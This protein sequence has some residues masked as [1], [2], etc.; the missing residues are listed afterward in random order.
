MIRLSGKQHACSL[1][2]FIYRLLHPPIWYG[3][4]K[5]FQD[6]IYRVTKVGKMPNLRAARHIV[7]EIR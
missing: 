2:M 5:R 7:S 4:I 3:N 1:Q 6:L